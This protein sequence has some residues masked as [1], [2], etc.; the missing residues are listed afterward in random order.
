MTPEA[1]EA[2]QQTK[3]P[4]DFFSYVAYATK[5]QALGGKCSQ[6]AKNLNNEG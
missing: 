5:D 6:V 4:A 2:H 1:T 3:R